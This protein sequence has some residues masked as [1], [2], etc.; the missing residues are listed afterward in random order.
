MEIAALVKSRVKQKQNTEDAD[1]ETLANRARKIAFST[2]NLSATEFEQFVTESETEKVL[3]NVLLDKLSIFK[4]C[5]YKQQSSDEK[6][7]S[8][9]MQ[10]LILKYVT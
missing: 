2:L 7:S 4:V 1:D 9:L 5:Y 8:R 6:L 10:Y 3:Y